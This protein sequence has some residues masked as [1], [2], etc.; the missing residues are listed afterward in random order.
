MIP[1]R[2]ILTLIS[3]MDSSEPSIPGD[4]RAALEALFR[5]HPPAGVGGPDRLHA[6]AVDTRHEEQ[7]IVN[8]LEKSEV[9]LGENGAPLS[10]LPRPQV[11]AQAFNSLAFPGN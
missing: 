8:L 3:S 9:F 2:A 11:V 4:N 7:F 10:P 1:A 5:H 6:V